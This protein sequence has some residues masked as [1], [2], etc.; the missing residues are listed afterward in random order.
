MANISGDENLVLKYENLVVYD[1]NF[2]VQ[3]ENLIPRYE[4]FVVQYEN[5]ILQDDNLA[6][7]YGNLVPQY[8]NFVL[9]VIGN[10]SAVI[11][12]FLDIFRDNLTVLQKLFAR[13][14]DCIF[15]IFQTF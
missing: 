7:K 13:F 8:E 11:F 9:I 5:L 2:I 3:Y 12:N 14:R 4:D 1:E 15:L 10:V 6:L